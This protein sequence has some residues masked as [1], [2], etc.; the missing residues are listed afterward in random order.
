MS[1]IPKGKGVEETR[2]WLDENGWNDVFIGWTADEIWDQTTCTIK[3]YFAKNHLD[4]MRAIR[5]CGLLNAERL[6]Y[7]QQQAGNKY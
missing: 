3:S 1:N 7:A 6:I 2:R 5:F 4:K